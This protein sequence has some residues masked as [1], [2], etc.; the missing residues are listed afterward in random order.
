MPSIGHLAVGL[1]AAHEALLFLPLF[2]VGLW[3]RRSERT[4]QG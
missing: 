2:V 1:A 4:V 3:P